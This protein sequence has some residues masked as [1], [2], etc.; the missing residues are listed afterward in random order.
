MSMP[1]ASGRLKMIFSYLIRR[2]SF[3]VGKRLVGY[4]GHSLDIARK[5]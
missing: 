2:G 5:S 4:E 1:Q 3:L